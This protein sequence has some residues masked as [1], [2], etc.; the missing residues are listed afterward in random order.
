MIS[1]SLQKLLVGVSAGNKVMEVTVV[2]RKP[3]NE[4]F[5]CSS[6]PAISKPK[7]R[8]YDESYLY[9]GFTSV[10]INREERPQCVLCLSVLAAD[11]MK[12]DKLK[13]HLET[14]RSE[15]KNNPKNTFVENF[16]TFASNKSHLRY[17]NHIIQSSFSMLSSSIQKSTK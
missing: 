9:F 14:K 5:P 3:S 1:V 11:S 10:V 4:P 13:W 17:H 8:K 12:P 16:M 2:K 6:Q 7:S 15:M